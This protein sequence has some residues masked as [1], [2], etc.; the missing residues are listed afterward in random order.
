MSK[1]QRVVAIVI[2]AFNEAVNI[3]RVVKSLPQHIVAGKE[4]FAVRVVVVDDC[5]RDN[6]YKQAKET[7]ATV[8][9]HVM[10]SGAGAA[11]RTGLRYAE[12]TIDNLAFVV[13]IDGDG[14][15]ASKDVERLVRFAID[16]GADM[17][18]GNRLHEGNK[19]SMPAHRNLGNWGLSLI[20]R[21]LFG[22]KVKDT[23]TGLRLFAASLV[24]AL[25][26]S[27]IDRY[28]AN[29]ELLWL[30]ERAG[31]NIQEMPISVKYSQETVANGQSNWGAV[32]LLLDL[33]WIRISR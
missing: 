29:T 18:V 3:Q 5:S 19:E 17:V 30:A 10:N 22:V 28:G 33:L 32:D 12:Q 31:A 9:R 16:H 14:Q 1:P 27:T 8:L 24:P 21:I 2:P 15:H 7:N 26:D 11:T 4:H 23:Q 6:T 13:T 20:S 25:V